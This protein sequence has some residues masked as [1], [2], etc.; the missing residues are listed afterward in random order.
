MVKDFP[1]DPGGLAAKA[2]VMTTANMEVVTRT[3]D[4]SASTEGGKRSGNAVE[5]G[6]KGSLTTH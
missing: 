2:E 3:G 4:G 1:E 6:G 5:I